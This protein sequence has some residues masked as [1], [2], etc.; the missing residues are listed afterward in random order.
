M[1]MYMYNIAYRNHHLRGYVG[2][3]KDLFWGASMA[4]MT[5]H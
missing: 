3:E 1:Y 5:Q 2:P 4:S